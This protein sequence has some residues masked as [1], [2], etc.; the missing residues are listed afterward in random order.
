MCPV[1]RQHMTGCFC[2]WTCSA[3]CVTGRPSF[4]C[5]RIPAA[6]TPRR[7]GDDVQLQVSCDVQVAAT[8]TKTVLLGQLCDLAF[9]KE[10]QLAVLSRGDKGFQSQAPAVAHRGPRN[11]SAWTG[12]CCRLPPTSCRQALLASCKCSVPKQVPY[13]CMSCAVRYC[14]LYCRVAARRQEHMSCFD[15]RSGKVSELH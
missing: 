4:R 11:V 7:H 8:R 6:R 14:C 1:Q 2:S 10:G 13:V 12:S 5:K 9:Y 15:W 3:A